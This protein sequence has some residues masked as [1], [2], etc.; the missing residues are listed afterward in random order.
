MVKLFASEEEMN[1]S[2]NNNEGD[3]AVVY[4]V[5]LTPVTTNTIVNTVSFPKQV[6]LSEAVTSEINGLFTYD[7][8]PPAAIQPELWQYLVLLT[9]TEYK[10]Y[11]QNIDTIVEYT[12]TDGITYTRV[13]EL[14]ND[15]YTFDLVNRWYASWD[16]IVLDSFCV[17]K[18]NYF[19]GLYEYIQ[20]TSSDF[21]L[22]DYSTLTYSNQINIEIGQNIASLD[23]FKP[24]IDALPRKDYTDCDIVYDGT[25]YYVL[26]YLAGAYFSHCY[27]DTDTGIMYYTIDIDA[28]SASDYLELPPKIYV[29]NNNF[30]ISDTIDTSTLN[31]PIFKW[32]ANP[33]VCYK[34]TEVD[35]NSETMFVR[36]NYIQSNMLYEARGVCYGQGIGEDITRYRTHYFFNITNII[37][38][39]YELVPTQLTLNNSNQLSKDIIAYGQ[40]GIVEGT[41]EPSPLTEEQYNKA[42]DT[43]QKILGIEQ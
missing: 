2:T 26:P 5:K 41:L 8:D 15:E 36:V 30:E 22:P 21:Y 24:I 17:N 10:V 13:T 32:G 4:G 1:E 23:R 14:D 42:L 16:N 3:L 28:Q 35:L 34:I 33:T 11:R 18:I 9:P 29:L 12:S 39:K 6:I 27:Y 31:E 25:N 7:E 20:Y 37:K 19:G 40:S 43:S 38:Y